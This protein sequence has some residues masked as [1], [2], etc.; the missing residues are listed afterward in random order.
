VIICIVAVSL[1]VSSLWLALTALHA[2]HW[3]LK[4]GKPKA[5]NC[6]CL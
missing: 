6:G 5:K 2:K 3:D 1:F 4:Y